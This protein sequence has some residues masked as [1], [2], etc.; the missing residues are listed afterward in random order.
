MLETIYFLQKMAGQH[1]KN[2]WSKTNRNIKRKKEYLGW[3]ARAVCTL[4]PHYSDLAKH[5]ERELIRWLVC[6]CKTRKNLSWI[7]CP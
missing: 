1:R 3:E 7:H 4:G 6:R 2:E 5:D